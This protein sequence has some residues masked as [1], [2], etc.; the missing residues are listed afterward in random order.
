MR[1]NQAYQPMG[2]SGDVP[3]K[4]ANFT[5]SLTVTQNENLE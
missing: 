3:G 4:C 5:S 2:A 1:W